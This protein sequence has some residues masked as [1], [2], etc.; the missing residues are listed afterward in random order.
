MTIVNRDPVK[1]P[2]RRPS[3]STYILVVPKKHAETISTMLK[4]LECSLTEVPKS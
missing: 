4:A 3:T 2:T 1:K